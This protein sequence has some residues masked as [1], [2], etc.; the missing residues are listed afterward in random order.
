LWFI[1]VLLLYTLNSTHI[2][3]TIPCA[4]VVIIVHLKADQMWGSRSHRRRLGGW[5]LVGGGQSSQ[6]AQWETFDDEMQ[7]GR[8]IP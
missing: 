6:I 7:H 1:Y 4:T 3:A 8:E 2:A 5:R